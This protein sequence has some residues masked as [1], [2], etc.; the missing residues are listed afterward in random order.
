MTIENNV[1]E[2]PVTGD[3]IKFIKTAVDTNG[4]LLELEYTTSKA[5]GTV[6]LHIHRIAEERFTVIRGKLGV[7]LGEKDV[8][9]EPGETA[10]IEPR[11]PHR[12]WNLDETETTFL[13]EIRPAL[14]FQT[15]FETVFGLARDGKVNKDGLPNFWQLMVLAQVADSYTAGAPDFLLDAI[16]GICAPLGKMLGYQASYPQYSGEAHG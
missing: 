4:E 1:I 14:H 16:I 6:P 10:V 9:L 15:Y 12:F 3:R 11:T 13:T 7:Q 8:A 5:G 2:N